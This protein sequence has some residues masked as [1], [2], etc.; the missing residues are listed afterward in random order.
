[1]SV[2]DLIKANA[3]LLPEPET[4]CI[5]K[6]SLRRALK[7]LFQK[8]EDDFLELIM[9][10]KKLK[11]W[12]EGLPVVLGMLYL[13]AILAVDGTLSLGGKTYTIDELEDLRRRAVSVL[14]C[15][16]LPTPMHPEDVCNRVDRALYHLHG[17][18]YSVLETAFTTK[19]HET[20]PRIG[21]VV[22]TAELLLKGIEE[23]K[24]RSLAS[25]VSGK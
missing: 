9:K 2:I 20:I 22:E 21:E 4:P 18:I 19:E 12:R 17:L 6:G 13:R 14:K 15:C 16:S 7:P 10:P 3:E 24:P 11:S 5:L 23:P 25:V 8:T 1:M